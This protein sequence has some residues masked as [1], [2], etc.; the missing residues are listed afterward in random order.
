MSSNRP[1]GRLAT[2]NS[3]P[4][5]QVVPVATVAAPDDVAHVKATAAGKH[6]KVSW[7]LGAPQSATLPTS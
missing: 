2:V 7:T 5:G 1:S 4:R 3:L 6:V